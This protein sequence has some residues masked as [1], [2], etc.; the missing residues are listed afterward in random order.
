M[1][2]NADGY[3]T[4]TEVVLDDIRYCWMTDTVTERLVNTTTR[5][6]T[7]VPITKETT[8]QLQGQRKEANKVSSKA[9]W[10]LFLLPIPLCTCCVFFVGAGVCFMCE[11]PTER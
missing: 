8:S 11:L 5:T 1:Y 3:R 2:L 4:V 9:W 6:T 10:L 7:T